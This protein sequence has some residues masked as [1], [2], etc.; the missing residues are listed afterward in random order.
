[1]ATNSSPSAGHAGEWCALSSV[2]LHER[3]LTSSPQLEYL[4]VNIAIVV[5]IVEIE[6]IAAT[7]PSNPIL[8]L[9]AMPTPSICFYL[10]FM[11][12]T[13]AVLNSMKYRLPFN[14][15]STPKGSICPPALYT[16]IEDS[17]AIEG[18][19]EIAYRLALRD[20]YN[21]S[22]MFRRMLIT[23][24]W[25]WGV[26]L[27]IAATVSTVLVMELQEHIAFGM[28]WGVPFAMLAVYAAITIVYVRRSLKEEKRM[29]REKAEAGAMAEST[30]TVS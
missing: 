20:R 3:T 17:V 29:W 1:M 2:L 12:L 24:T 8:R 14:M 7:A 22:P 23:L 25:M 13:T 16:F 19:G 30:S 26:G 11:F 10:G 5:T 6:L 18:R 28:G 4:Q 27:L 15:S 21:A 9:C